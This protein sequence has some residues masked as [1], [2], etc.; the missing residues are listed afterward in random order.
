MSA[1]FSL[2]LAYLSDANFDRLAVATVRVMEGTPSTLAEIAERYIDRHGVAGDHSNG[3][4]H[5][6]YAAAGDL[7]LA[8]CQ[9]PT[10]QDCSVYEPLACL[11]IQGAK[12]IVVGEETTIC[13]AG[14]IMIGSH[15]LPVRTRIAA[16]STDQPYLVAILPLDIA[17][18]R[19][20]YEQVGRRG[21]ATD[22]ATSSLTAEPSSAELIDAFARYMSAID[23]QL[24]E[25]VVAPLIAKE[26]HYRLLTSPSG[27]MLRSLLFVDSHAS[28]IAEALAQIRSNFRQPQA[29][30]ELAA[31]AG[32]SV[33]SFHEHFK[34][35]TGTTPLQYQKDLRLIE[36]RRDMASNA[37]LSASEAGY[38]VG[39]RSPTQFSREYARKFGVPPRRDT[40]NANL[41]SK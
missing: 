11:I 36:A 10:E 2:E 8:R 24:D 28:R 37:S 25:E 19:G 7:M 17:E 16:A 13:N 27:G 38:R 32:L 6:R 23:G 22:S 9:S 1:R 29:V 5:F 3:G 4:S 14:D 18:I 26:I 40:V 15:E 31:M 12:E 30:A 20:L 34:A 35:V 39:Y 33:S 41:A 21:S